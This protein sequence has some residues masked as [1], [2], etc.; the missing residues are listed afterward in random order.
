MMKPNLAIVIPVYKEAA[1]IGRVLTGL[2]PLGLP[3]LVVDDDSQDGTPEVVRQHPWASCTVRRGQRGLGSAVRE[4]VRLVGAELVL[5]MDGDGQHDPADAAMLIQ[6]L[7]PG[8]DIV[9]GSRFAEGAHLT[10]L[11]RRR[12]LLSKTLDGVANVLAK[13]RTSDPMTGFAI[14]PRGLILTTKTN[15]F[16][17]LYEILA[18]R[19]LS[20]A[21][22]G[23][24]FMPRMAGRSKATFGEVLQLLK[25]PRW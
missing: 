19:R 25:T 9:V 20:V 18:N 22:V 4:G 11:S 5:V 17:W 10:G 14:A 1:N 21:E 2:A 6:A 8:V 7:R 15:G 13:T 16:K 12:E 3:C 24:R 23:I